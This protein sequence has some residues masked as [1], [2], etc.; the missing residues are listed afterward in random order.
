[1][2]GIATCLLIQQ[3]SSSAGEVGLHFLDELGIVLDNM[4]FSTRGDASCQ[5]QDLVHRLQERY[6]GAG[7]CGSIGFLGY[8]FD[9]AA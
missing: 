1:M 2:A 9:V 8:M 3:C 6:E 7:P 4:Y 5:V